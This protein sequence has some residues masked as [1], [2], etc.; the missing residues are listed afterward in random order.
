M[1]KRKNHKRQL[2]KNQQMTMTILE[3]V[4]IEVDRHL[5][6]ATGHAL[7]PP[8][9]IET[10]VLEVFEDLL[11][12]MTTI[13]DLESP[14]GDHDLDQV[15]LAPDH[16]EEKEIVVVQGKDRPIREN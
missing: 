4:E 6:Q 12:M 11:K 1:R 15:A 16:L 10:V 9:V 7:D 3:N 14:E 2:N 8:G 13:P 5:D